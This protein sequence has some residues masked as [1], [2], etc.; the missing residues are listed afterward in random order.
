MMFFLK[1]RLFKWRL[2]LFTSEVWFQYHGCHHSNQVVDHLMVV[3]FH[4]ETELQDE[5][6]FKID[7]NYEVRLIKPVI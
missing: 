1:L 6:V 4:V 2:L 7:K 3:A 5:E